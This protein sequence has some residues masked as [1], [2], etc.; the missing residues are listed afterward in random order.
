MILNLHQ[1][2]LDRLPATRGQHRRGPC[3]PRDLS[4]VR[5]SGIGT[6]AAERSG[7]SK[8]QLAG[9]NEVALDY[10]SMKLALAWIE[11]RKTNEP[12]NN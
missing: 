10:Q 8:I 7:N 3:L 9:W 1:L 11:M 12:D 6:D 2:L 5:E 4:K